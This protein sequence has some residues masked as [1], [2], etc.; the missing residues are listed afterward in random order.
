[1][2][3]FV[4]DNNDETMENTTNLN[5][6]TQEIIPILPLRSMVA[7]PQMSVPFMISF[8]S[9]ALIEKV[10]Q[11]DRRVGLLTVK[12]PSVEH[13]VP[14]QLYE[15]GTIA[16]ILH[17][18]KNEDG[19]MIAILSGIR[20]FKVSTWQSDGTHLKAS[21]VNAPEIVES[22]IELDALQRQLRH[23]VLEVLAM[24][25]DASKDAAEMI[26]RVE[27]PL[28]LAYVTAFNM[29]LTTDVRQNLLEI[30]SASQKIRKLLSHL[31]REREMLSIGKKIQSEVH[32]KMSKSQR[33]YYLKQQLKAIQKELGETED[34]T[35]EPDAYAERIEASDMPDEARKEASRE[36]GRMQQMSPQSAEY[37][38]IK[39][40]LDWLI[41]WPWKTVSDDSGDISNAR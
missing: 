3:S 25:P 23:T 6:D 24:T 32:E 18:K 29:N 35:S 37:P 11:A 30:D 26:S 17:A 5:T 36:L 13:P 12:D 1:M 8:S 21:V 2:K 7:F 4:S 34:A 19:S 28:Q 20:R 27:D 40:Y 15:V 22:G 14:G 10:M 16:K 31:S 41:D 33:E 9:V 39:T 38:I